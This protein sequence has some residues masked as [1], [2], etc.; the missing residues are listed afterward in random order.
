MALIYSTL[1]KDIT[2]R[3]WF[4]QIVLQVY[5]KHLRESTHRY[6]QVPLKQ[7]AAIITGN[8]RVKKVKLQIDAQRQKSIGLLASCMIW[9][10]CQTM[11]AQTHKL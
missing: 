5:L 8:P 1:S 10:I 7:V 4:I 3:Q 2:V 11:R 6:V 9:V